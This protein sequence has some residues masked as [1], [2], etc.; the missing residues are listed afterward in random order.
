MSQHRLT[1]RQKAF[2]D[3]TLLIHTFRTIT[4]AYIHIYKPKGSRRTSTASASRIYNKPAVVA[5]RNE[6]R[7][8]EAN[9]AIYRQEAEHQ[10]FLNRLAG[11][12]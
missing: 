2:I 4:D 5:Y 1:P 7:Q 10:A 9:R 6:L 11:Y 8:I 12:I 3:S